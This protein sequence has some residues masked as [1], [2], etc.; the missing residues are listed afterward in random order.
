[1]RSR[2]GTRNGLVCSIASQE[3]IRDPTSK[4]LQ[5]L[6]PLIE[7]VLGAGGIDSPP[8][9]PEAQPPA[10]PEPDS[11]GDAGHRSQ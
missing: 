2:T 10:I 6:I 8:P 4:L 3:I 11:P 9:A 7:D 5:R 1:M